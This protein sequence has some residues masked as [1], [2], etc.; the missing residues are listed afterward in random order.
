MREREATRRCATGNVEGA[1]V[2]GILAAATAKQH[3]RAEP[4]GEERHPLYGAQALHFFGSHLNI[5]RGACGLP[6]TDWLFERKLVRMV[7]VG[8]HLTGKR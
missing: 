4:Q 2:S 7:M 3:G 8:Y 6:F 1:R 5:K